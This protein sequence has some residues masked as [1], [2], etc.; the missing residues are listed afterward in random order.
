[1]KRFDPPDLKVPAV[2]QDLV[3]DLRDRRLL[4]LVG[5]LLVTIV[6][7]PLLLS[8]TS[9]SPTPVPAVA[10]VIGHNPE[11]ELT[12]AQSDPGLRVPR[13]R[14]GYLKAKD[15]FKQH[16]TGP[17]LNPGSE[18][19]EPPAESSTNPT[20]S[21]AVTP[22]ETS[23][24]PSPESTEP[25]PGSESVS[26]KGS[27]HSIP[28]KQPTGKQE[29]SNSNPNPETGG[30]NNS[31]EVT[32]FTFAIDAKVT[33][34]T[35]GEDGKPKSETVSREGLKPPQAL[36][37]EHTQVLTYTGI[38]PKT[39]NPLFMV[40]PEVTAIYGEVKCV[41]GNGICQL[42]ELERSFSATFV[43]GP[44][45]ARYKI[46]VLNVEPVAAGHL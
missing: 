7:A 45:Q 34:I 41:S 14:L 5:L 43:R 25:T 35:T 12:V 15:P 19:I 11:T 9:S 1:M 17:V 27:A 37:G 6:A 8:R 31:S 42:V 3:A 16:Y 22:V 2:L 39:K 44:A 38:S 36:P 28:G 32:I 33:K 46:D 23:A 24:A 18:P 29:G 10:P 30:S 20:S 4:P 40:S 21:P 26:G 13:K